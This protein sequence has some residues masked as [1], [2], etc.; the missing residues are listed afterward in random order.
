M[1][2]IGNTPNILCP[3]SKELSNFKC[4]IASRFNK[5]RDTATELDSKETFLKT[6]SSVLNN[7][8]NLNIQFK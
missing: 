2:R 5:L 1:H 3:I 8:G 4:N 6:W 7:N